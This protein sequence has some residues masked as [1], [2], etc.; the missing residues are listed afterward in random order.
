[1][2]PPW[3]QRC[4]KEGRVEGLQSQP[5]K[6]SRR[7]GRAQA[8]HDTMNKTE[9]AYARMLESM[10]AKHEIREYAFQPVKFRLADKTYYTPDFQVVCEDWTVEYIDVKGRSGDKAWCE[11]D[12]RVKIK[13]CAELHPFAFKIVWPQKGGGW[14]V[15]EF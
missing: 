8:R 3:L 12:A 1:M 11:D 5:V 7:G 9:A 15:E 14:G 2:T 6:P 4:V 10:K 13:V